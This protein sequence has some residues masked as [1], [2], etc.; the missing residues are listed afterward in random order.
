MNF[1][2]VVGILMLHT[3][4]TAI[5]AAP[6]LRYEDLDSNMTLTSPLTS[7]DNVLPPDPNVI[8]LPAVGRISCY[9]YADSQW[10][11]DIYGL[12]NHVASIVFMHLEGGLADQPVRYVRRYAAGHASFLID[13][14]SQLTWRMLFLVVGFVGL[15]AE[16]YT[17]GTFLLEVSGGP[18]GDW[19]GSLTTH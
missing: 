17:A 16:Q 15:S 1:I 7:A 5:A 8:V 14:S 18:S 2:A 13:P 9:S 12:L 3:Y 4:T 11:D 19:N 6:P 10:T